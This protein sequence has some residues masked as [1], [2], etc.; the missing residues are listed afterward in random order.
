[1]RKMNTIPLSNSAISGTIQDMTD[2]V[3]GTV[4]GRIRNSELFAI[5]VDES[6]DV[7]YIAVLLV[8]ARYLRGS[9][10]EEN[11]LLCLPLSK[12][13][14]GEDIHNATECYFRLKDISCY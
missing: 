5:Q 3:D 6:T 7:A 4:R 9:E 12:C 13:T 14:R 2:D 10:V 11:L 1:M 8:I